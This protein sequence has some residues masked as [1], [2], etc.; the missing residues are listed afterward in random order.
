[1][2]AA[3]YIENHRTSWKNS[4]HAQQWENTLD[5]YAVIGDT[6]VSAIDTPMIVK[7]L[8]PIW[9]TKSE[10][11]SRVRGRIE[12][13]LDAAK[14]MGKRTGENPTRWRGHLDKIL[15]RRDRA[16]KVKHHPALPWQKIPEFMAALAQREAPA[17]PCVD[18]AYSRRC[19]DKRGFARK[20]RRV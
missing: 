5:A 11:A 18:P 3:E 8:K 12:S 4:K 15:P 13:I 2:A 17:A 9:S 14:V 20:G 19:S 6:D 16:K 1:M 7:I 10:T